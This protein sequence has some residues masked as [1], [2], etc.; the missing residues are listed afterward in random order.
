MV[1]TGAAAPA[2][3]TDATGTAWCEDARLLGSLFG[4]THLP[5][6]QLR[7]HS[8]VASFC[9]LVSGFVKVGA[10]GR[11]NACTQLV[12]KCM[13]RT[14]LRSIDA[15]ALPCTGITRPFAMPN[16]GLAAT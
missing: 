16:C 9:G 10:S 15:A 11:H 7:S 13:F 8:D 1:R 4:L 6:S 14:P 2:S 5:A 3:S 12:T